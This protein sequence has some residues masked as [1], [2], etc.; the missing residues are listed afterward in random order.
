LAGVFLRGT[1]FFAQRTF[2]LMELNDRQREAAE[3]V[4][5]DLERR[6]AVELVAPQGFGKTHMS[7]ALAERL[8]S[9]GKISLAVYVAP[10]VDLAREVYDR[11]RGRVSA[12]M[13]LLLGKRNFQCPAFNV[14]A[15]KAQCWEEPSGFRLV[16][17]KC[18]GGPTFVSSAG[19]R[20][21]A[22]SYTAVSRSGEVK[23]VY[24]YSSTCP[25]SRQYFT[26]PQAGIIVT[27]APK[28]IIDHA[29]GLLPKVDLVVYDEAHDAIETYLFEREIYVSYRT[30]R[31]LAKAASAVG[32]A[33]KVVQE[34]VEDMEEGEADVFKAV[35]AAA[36][37]GML[38]MF[39]ELAEL[40]AWR[41]LMA[42]Y[43]VE[44]RGGGVTVRFKPDPS[45]LIPSGAGVLL[46]SVPPALG[47]LSALRRLGVK[48]VEVPEAVP[49]VLKV[50]LTKSS[51]PVSVMRRS[52]KPIYE[53]E[54]LRL[55][56]I[57]EVRRAIVALWSASS[58]D[59]Y[60]LPY[61]KGRVDAKTVKKWQ[62]IDVLECRDTVISRAPYPHK[63]AYPDPDVYKYVALRYT[64]NALRGARSPSPCAVHL[65]AFDKHI[66]S[67]IAEL[68]RYFS[69]VEYHRLKTM[70]VE[71]DCGGEVKTVDLA[72]AD[73]QT[74]ESLLRCRP[75]REVST[76]LEP[77]S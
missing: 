38:E 20:R 70:L 64:M 32:N 65:F 58:L 10:T 76:E 17:Y 34:F 36:A 15:D 24:L 27:T 18:F 13:A 37:L 49:H 75:L 72:S 30:L 25:Y 33:P 55:L 57:A 63:E 4:L 50:V 39:D 8:L 12:V 77:F 42:K 11:Y 54:H 7:I 1:T 19:G 9:Q 3:A 40:Y 69:R 31:K 47:R 68:E 41:R 44:E 48:T 23:R 26:L 67:L 61:F 56:L 62:G 28:F 71:Y 45:A 43:V 5:Q 2:R 22:A 16:A 29:L 60:Y 46:L 53:T 74:L 66:V 6:R 73:R 21:A 14:E 59:G 51:V 52:M 35:D